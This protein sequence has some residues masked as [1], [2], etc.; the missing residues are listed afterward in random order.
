M[1]ENQL[2]EAP[3]IMDLS[4]KDLMSARF[5]YKHG[6]SGGDLSDLKKIINKFVSQANRMRRPKLSPD[7]LGDVF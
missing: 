4:A 7:E 6:L 3:D 1:D 5:G 2:N